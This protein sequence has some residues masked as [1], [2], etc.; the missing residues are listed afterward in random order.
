MARTVPAQSRGGEGDAERV[1][2]RRGGHDA[3]PPLLVVERRE[4]VRGAPHLERAGGLPALE[5]EPHVGP[6][7]GEALAQRRRPQVSG[8]DRARPLD[9]A[10]AQSR[11]HRGLTP[12][13]AAR[14]PPPRGRGAARRSGRRSRPRPGRAGGRA[15]P[16]PCRRERTGSPTRRE[17]RPGRGRPQSPRMTWRV[18]RRARG[19]TGAPARAAAMKAPSRKG[20]RPV[21]ATNVPS[22]KKRTVFPSRSAR[23]TRSASVT[24]CTRVPAV[25][26]QVAAAADEGADQREAQHLALGHEEEIG[27]QEGERAR[28]RRRRRR[29]SR[30]GRAGRGGG[31]ARGPRPRGGSRRGGGPRARRSATGRRRSVGSGRR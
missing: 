22:G 1:V 15:R 3:A 24:L 19:T 6:G 28:P 25:H 27:G 2:P 11:G 14:A 8:E 12:T 18:P 30:P 23:P 20:R 5:L 29:G 31:G 26:R 13:G 4:E 10:E 7:H 9:V 21:A 17:I 16:C